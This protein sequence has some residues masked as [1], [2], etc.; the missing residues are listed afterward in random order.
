LLE[1]GCI[2]SEF[3]TRRRR[4]YHT[5][6]LVLDGLLRASKDAGDLGLGGTL[7]GTS[8][9]HLAM[10]YGIPPVGTV[11]HEW[12]M[13]VAAITNAYEHVSEIC[14]RYWVGTFG[15]GVGHLSNPLR[16]IGT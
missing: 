4:D 11:A 13:G 9:V 12:F 16:A 7:S 3:G 1:H 2:F 5:Q 10:K 6:R 14:L 8:N 15:E